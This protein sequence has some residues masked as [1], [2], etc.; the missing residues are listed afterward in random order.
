MPAPSLPVMRSTTH[1]RPIRLRNPDQFRLIG[2]CTSCLTSP[3]PGALLHENTGSR[4]HG[5]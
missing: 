3:K 2:R 5:H 4:F 1:Q